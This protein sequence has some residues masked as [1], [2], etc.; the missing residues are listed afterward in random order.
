MLRGV[1]VDLVVQMKVDHLAVDLEAPVPVGLLEAF[2]LPA[3]CD[4][5][6]CTAAGAA[7]GAAA[8]GEADELAA[9]AAGAI[10]PTTSSPSAQTTASSICGR[11]QPISAS[12]P[13]SSIAAWIAAGAGSS[14]WGASPSTLLTRESLSRK[15]MAANAGRASFFIHVH[16]LEYMYM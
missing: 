14:S 7:V 4:D 13:M 6:G 5:G 9:A 11:R 8:A 1:V 2:R 16:V 12:M 3:A 10:S 15:L